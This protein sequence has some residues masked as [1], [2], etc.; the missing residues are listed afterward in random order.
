M[1]PTSAARKPK[2]LVFKQQKRTREDS[3][4]SPRNF[5]SWKSP[6]RQKWCAR[7]AE[8]GLRAADEMLRSLCIIF[9]TPPAHYV[10]FLENTSVH[11]AKELARPL[12][13]F[14][15]IVLIN[16]TLTKKLVLPRHSSKNR[17]YT[18]ESILSRSGVKTPFFN[19][20]ARGCF[21]LRSHLVGNGFMGRGDRVASRCV[22]YR[23]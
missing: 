16:D 5:S 13:A 1:R 12:R 9:C 20:Y 4:I 21:T 10:I 19:V 17:N 11:R 8:R 22:L 18:R 7:A 15:K 23:Y 3:G 2:T 14:I 6:R